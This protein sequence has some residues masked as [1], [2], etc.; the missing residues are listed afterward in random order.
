MVETMSGLFGGGGMSVL[1]KTGG[2]V[3]TTLLVV[4]AVL[5][6]FVVTVDEGSAAIRTRNGKPIIRR[7][8]RGRGGEPGEVVVLRPGSHGAFPI[9]YWYRM[10]DMRA[11]STDLPPRQLTAASGHQHLVHASFD[12]RPL[13]T[14]H[15]LRIFELDVVNVNE[16]AGNIVGAALRDTVH[17]LEGAVLP[18]NATVSPLITSACAEHVRR[19][20]GIELLSVT[21]TGDALTD[22]YL[23]SGALTAAAGTG[24]GTDD[25]A[26]GASAMLAN[27]LTP[28]G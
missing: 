16:R 19:G 18:P 28:A 8:S 10:V 24:P 6:L 21:V 17:G 13:S 25:W 11:R 20:C 26:L 2:A 4:P 3:L 9:L 22:G 15:D 1:L 23:L 14:G 7:V 12:W 27:R 5:K